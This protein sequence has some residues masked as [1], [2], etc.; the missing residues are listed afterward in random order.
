MIERRHLN[1]R[2]HKRVL[3]KHH[4]RELLTRHSARHPSWHHPWHLTWHSSRHHPWHLQ[5]RLHHRIRHHLLL[6][7]IIRI[8]TMLVIVASM[9]VL[10]VPCVMLVTVAAMV[11]MIFTFLTWT[12]AMVRVLRLPCSCYRFF[13][14]FFIVLSNFLTNLFSFLPDDLLVFKHSCLNFSS[15]R[16]NLFL[17]NRLIKSLSGSFFTLSKWRR[18]VFILCVNFRLSL[19][20]L[21]ET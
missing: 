5:W 4:P 16:I 8:T 21:M 20:V 13:L 10:M 12:L 2:L 14:L 3:A 15:F 19:E 7:H 17:L 11:P 9:L 18:L 6:L 1:A